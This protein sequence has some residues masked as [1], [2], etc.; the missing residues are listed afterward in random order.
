MWLVLTSLI[1]ASGII[2]CESTFLA[3]SAVLITTLNSSMKYNIFLFALSII[4][5]NALIIPS[6]VKAQKLPDHDTTYYVTYPGTIVGRF[7]FSKKYATFI[8]PATNDGQNL[9]YKANTLRNMGI[10]ATYNNLTINIGYG[11]GFLNNGEGKGKTKSFDLQA[12]LYPH[13]W[14]VDVIAI[15]HKGV[16]SES[17]SYPHDGSDN[18]Y[19]RPDIQQLFIGFSGYRVLN[20]KRFSFNAAMTQNEWQKKSAGTLMIGGLVYYGQIKGDSSLVPKQ[21]ES[22]FPQA[23]GIDNVSSFSIGIGGGYAYTLVVAKYFYL[24]GSLIAN[25]NADFSAVE[26]MNDKKNKTVVKPST[27][28]K[29]A[30]GYNSNSWNISANWAANDLWT[31]ENYFSN[32]LSVSAGNYRLI[33]SKKIALR[34]H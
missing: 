5:C 22:S 2:T 14:A 17:Q 26:N 3:K 18:Y 30:I 23:S 20:S 15:R 1:Y 32:D 34:K 33:F 24:T 7:Y 27:I 28:Y 13:K 9:E 8:L 10:G 19:Y 21:L 25:L 29:A 16:Y 11:F 12:H 4:F 6:F 31:G